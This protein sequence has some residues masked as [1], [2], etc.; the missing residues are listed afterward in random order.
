MKKTF[1]HAARAALCLICGL[2]LSALELKFFGDIP[3]LSV[4]FL[5]ILAVTIPAVFLCAGAKGNVLYIFAYTLV[6]AFLFEIVGISTDIRILLACLITQALLYAQTGF[7]VN[8]ERFKVKKPAFGVSLVTILICVS[9]AATL[10]LQV[11]RHV[12]QPLL[13]E[14]EKYAILY[15]EPPP[16]PEP[17]IHTPPPAVPTHAN[18]DAG[19]EPVAQPKPPRAPLNPLLIPAVAAALVLL[20]CGYIT[21]RYV[22]YKRWLSRTLAAPPAEQVLVFYR[23]L[24]RALGVCGFARPENETPHELLCRTELASFFPPSAELSAVTDIF[25][26]AQYGGKPVSDTELRQYTDLFT[27]LPGLV[28]TRLGRRFY[29]LRYLR[30][31]Y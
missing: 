27:A 24:L 12:L 19:D 4:Y 2:S 23:H 10:T 26:A 16:P 7:S 28:K 21:F 31:M 29:Y 14:S 30:R 13:P 9:I 5:L 25:V 20:L 22:R 11:Y 18:T 15:Y 1:H 6:I 8:A 17:E 3:Y